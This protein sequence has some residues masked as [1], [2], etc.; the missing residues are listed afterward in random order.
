MLTSEKAALAKCYQIHGETM[1]K[2]AH[3]QRAM[4][5]F[6]QDFGPKRKTDI[7]GCRKSMY[8]TA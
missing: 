3:G 8:K 2:L 1:Y 6:D 5:F 7:E 4:M